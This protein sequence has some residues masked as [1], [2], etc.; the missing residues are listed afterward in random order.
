MA[1]CNTNEAPWIMFRDN[2][3][4]IPKAQVTKEKTDT[5]NII[6]IKNLCA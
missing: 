5:F 3:L 2:S 1:K 4:L 6:T